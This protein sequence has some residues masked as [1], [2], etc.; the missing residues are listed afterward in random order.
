MT[1]WRLDPAAIRAAYRQAAE[2]LVA[3]V[4][5]MSPDDWDRPAL[6]E[7]TVRDVAGHAG[8]ALST[9]EDYLGAVDS[10][11]PAGGAGHPLDYYAGIAGSGP[12]DH[13]AV[14]E[15]GRAAGRALGDDPAAALGEL[16]RRV[17]A[18]VDRAPDDAMVATPFGTLRV[19]DYL[20]SRVFE[21][22]VH[23]LDLVAAI[24]G[25]VDA[26]ARTGAADP[27]EL[28]LV[29]A[30]GL[31]AARADAATALLALTGRRPL[32]EGYSAI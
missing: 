1:S 21:L 3:T 28:S 9:V 32:P 22:A 11:K 13:A 2:E 18:V 24:G 27:V 12:L 10:G 20:P 17:L 14:A 26:K 8:R 30:A 23:R 15:R 19:V 31:A 25:D 6:G 16:A 7:W 4:A 29:V 5:G